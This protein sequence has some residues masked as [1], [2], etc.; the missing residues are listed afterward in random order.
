VSR[1]PLPDQAGLDDWAREHTFGL[2]DRF[3]VRRDPEL[4]LVLATAL[5]TRVSWQVPFTTVPASWLGPASRWA[6]QLHEVLCTPRGR[7][8]HDQ[9]V[10][11][12]AEAGDVAV[13]R[14]AARDGLAVVSVAAAPDVP[15]ATVLAAAHRIGRQLV[16]GMPVRRRELSELPLG[17]GPLGQVREETSAGGPAC[18]AVLPAWSAS[19]QHDL[20][21]PVLGFAAAKDAL[22]PGP[23]PWQAAQSVQARYSRTGFEAA[24]VS[25]V[26][27]A[28][29][30]RL[31]ATRRVAELRFG[32]PYAVVALAVDPVPAGGAGQPGPWHGLPVFSAWV[33]EP[34]DAAGT[35]DGVSSLPL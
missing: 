16:T 10:A 12:T 13:H 18:T 23:Q 7:R 20:S 32:H 19:G 25:S 17:D 8:G 33:S 24:A 22:L 5:A 15:A 29:A 11:V 21:A 34:E 3:P 9:F 4:L 27:I 35:G 1:G 31:P 2:I 28:A 26:A 30:A 14:A 6:G